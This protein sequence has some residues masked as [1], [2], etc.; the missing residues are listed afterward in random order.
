MLRNLNIGELDNPIVKVHVLALD[1]SL[2]NKFKGNKYIQIFS[3][4]FNLFRIFLYKINNQIKMSLEILHDRT[5]DLKKEINF[6]H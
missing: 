5:N 2:N 1:L 4:K 6:L 3:K